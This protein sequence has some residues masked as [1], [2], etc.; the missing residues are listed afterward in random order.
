MA[1][2]DPPSLNMIISIHAPWTMLVRD[3]VL[4][5][6]GRRSKRRRLVIVSDGGPI[7]LKRGKLSYFL[8]SVHYSD[9]R[10]NMLCIC[11]NDHV[12]LPGCPKERRA[13]TKKGPPCS[14][15]TR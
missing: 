13:L 12:D 14:G 11:G 5:G 3:P 7:R 1:I 4:M 8:M 6:W 10:Y 2:C 15:N 9:L